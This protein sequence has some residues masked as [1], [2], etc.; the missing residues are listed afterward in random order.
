M[1]SSNWGMATWS[2]SYRM[3]SIPEDDVLLATAP[4]FRGETTLYNGWLEE[5]SAGSDDWGEGE[6]PSADQEDF[7]VCRPGGWSGS[8]GRLHD[9]SAAGMDNMPQDSQEETLFFDGGEPCDGAQLDARATFEPG[10]LRAA[11][12]SCDEDPKGSPTLHADREVR[13]AA[14][15]MKK[16][17]SEGAV[18]GAKKRGTKLPPVAGLNFNF[19]ECYKIARQGAFLKKNKIKELESQ[20]SSS[21]SSTKSTPRLPQL[22][23]NGGKTQHSTI[24]FVAPKFTTADLRAFGPIAAEAF[25]PTECA[26]RRQPET[27]LLANIRP[28]EVRFAPELRANRHL[29]APMPVDRARVCRQPRVQLES[30]GEDAA[31]SLPALGPRSLSEGALAERAATHDARSEFDLGA[32]GFLPDELDRLHDTF[33]RFRS[34]GLSGSVAGELLGDAL[35]H[36]GYVTMKEETVAFVAQAP[37]DSALDFQGFAGFVWDYAAFEHEHVRR[38][39]ETLAGEGG[40][41]GASE[42]AFLLSRFGIPPIRTAVFE[43]LEAAGACEEDGLSADGLQRLA[44]AYRAAGGF[45]REILQD[46]RRAF[47]QVAEQVH[48]SGRALL[49]VDCLEETLRLALGPRCGSRA[50]DL[51]AT[52]LAGSG[53]GGAGTGAGLGVWEFVACA[54]RLREMEVNEYKRQ[55][56]SFDRSSQ[57]VIRAE[58]VVP[59][60]TSLG[61]VLSRAAVAEFI[62]DASDGDT[63]S[64]VDFEMFVHC[65]EGIH[66][67]EGFTPNQV[68][69]LRTAFE[70]CARGVSVTV[71]PAEVPELLS[72]LG[73][74]VSLNDARRLIDVVQGPNSTS[75][76]FRSFLRMVPLCRADDDAHAIAL[77]EAH[78]DAHGMLPVRRLAHALADMQFEDGSG[79]VVAAQDAAGSSTALNLQAFGVCVAAGR[80][81]HA[82]RRRE[83]AGLPEEEVARLREAFD[84]FAGQGRGTVERLE[85][86]DLLTQFQVP[87]RSAEERGHV[88]RRLDQ[89]RERALVSGVP[90][91]DLGESQGPRVHF[92]VMVHLVRI[93]RLDR[94]EA[95]SQ[96]TS[97]AMEETSFTQREADEFREVFDL[98]VSRRVERGG[99]G[100]PTGAESSNGSCS[101]SGSSSP[102]GTP[103]PGQLAVEDVRRV[104]RSLGLS[105]NGRQRGELKRYLTGQGADIGLDF[106]TFLRLMRWMLDGNFADI[107]G[108]SARALALAEEAADPG[109]SARRRRPR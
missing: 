31:T 88:F 80:R 97:Q 72:Y 14:R 7:G 19:E 61:H 8:L 70:S 74:S 11:A 53:P 103:S 18:R 2:P 41:I 105:L 55:F 102:S 22:A 109:N 52:F 73:H 57:G 90:S 99:G 16:S 4:A 15:K 39:F 5:L 3:E 21:S 12:A 82:C 20:E 81:A 42:A 36:L 84:D 75:V 6:V 38:Q 24:S 59:V 89:A 48:G 45:P 40:R 104:L 43:A 106:A 56:A 46:V 37:L 66:A 78:C 67:G 27:G 9:G 50:Q 101:P 35:A 91:D 33:A 79:A 17:A 100:S 92:W 60:L 23:V 51:Q 10:V 85:L 96:H 87:A 1:V 26:G 83:C 68:G 86:A 28:S 58:D 63:V 65:M 34:P 62:A 107:R 47:D 108:A 54:R 71:H 49:S 69:E 32:N 13:R 93:L 95:E 29:P 64:E 76:G 30:L 25:E 94:E 98:W 77:H 44:A